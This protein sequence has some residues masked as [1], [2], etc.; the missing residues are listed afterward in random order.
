M[1]I[2]EMLEKWE[3]REK[4]IIQ[5]VVLSFIGTIIIAN[6]LFLLPY[7]MSLTSTIIG[8]VRMINFLILGIAFILSGTFTLKPWRTRKGII[9]LGSI[10]TFIGGILILST[11]LLIAISLIRLWGTQLL[12]HTKV[13]SGVMIGIYLIVV[14]LYAGPEKLSRKLDSEMPFIKYTNG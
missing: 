10:S 3:P 14:V 4:R 5:G 1:V 12:V 9:V 8:M 6:I 11:M 2:N 13:L 7:M